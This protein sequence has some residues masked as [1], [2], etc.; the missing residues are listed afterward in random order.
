MKDIKTIIEGIV[1]QGK[2]VG[3]RGHAF[4]AS[5]SSGSSGGKHDHGLDIGARRNFAHQMATKQRVD[6]SAKQREQE[7][8]QRRKEA[9]QRHKET[10]KMAKE[11]TIEEGAYAKH[12][13]DHLKQM[14]ARDVGVISRYKGK[15]GSGI[16]DVV[17]REHAV[18][19]ELA[20]R[21]HQVEK[22]KHKLVTEADDSSGT[23][24]RVKIKNV[25]RMDDPAPT[26]EKSTLSKTGQIK[27]KIIDEEKP[28]M[29]DKHFGLPASLIDSVR[30][31]VEKKHED[32]KTLVKG[33]KTQVDLEPETD[34]KIDEAGT[35]KHTVPKTEKHKKL[36]ALAHP[37]D[38]ITHKDILVGRGVVK[39]EEAEQIDE[40]SKATLGSYVKKVAALPPEKVKPSREK[41]IEMASKKLHGEEL[42][43]KE[44]MK[45]G[46][47]NKEE[48]EL[49]DSEKERIEELARSFPAE[50]DE[51]VKKS[52]VPTATT[53]TS[54]PT[55]G[56]NQD[57][58]GF[59][60]KN[61]TADYTISDEKKLRK[62]ETDLVESLKDAAHEAMK[63]AHNAPDRAKAAINKLADHGKDKYSDAAMV[64]IGATRAYLNRGN[65]D[66][67]REHWQQ[68]HAAIKEETIAEG[69]G[70][71]RKNPLP[72]GKETE[73]DDTHKHPLQQLE[74][75]SHAV[76]G[77]E[78]HFEHKDGSKSKISRHLARHIVAVHNSMR[79]TQEK[80]NFAQKVHANRES[81]KS[82]VSKHL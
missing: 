57:Q 78:P 7:V 24:A 23:K 72:D 32:D 67:A 12:E 35:K 63:V 11:E 14:H 4:R 36:A 44:K 10:A 76:E 66:K 13:T 8:E 17:D 30:Q 31:I 50:V 21:G 29:S 52:S 34:D 74:K 58:S 80:D 51:A 81:M 1:S 9:E 22:P 39:E 62:E 77:N 3:S 49:S 82:E 40:V 26:S 54:A 64:H 28:F 46:M 15:M 48:V 68:A 65:V 56:A 53:A 79:T 75:I 18:R 5:S 47:Y 19:K 73:G 41:G 55:R 42:S 37:K 45:R 33:G 2:F 20:K 38:K 60:P 69:R 16:D 59:G 43:S 6:Q 27:T 61:N 25:A 70:R 71:P